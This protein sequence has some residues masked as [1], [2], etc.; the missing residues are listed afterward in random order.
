MKVKIIFSVL[1]TMLSWAS[2][3]RNGRMSA[4]NPVDEPTSGITQGQIPEVTLKALQ[5][6]KSFHVSATQSFSKAPDLK[7]PLE[8]IAGKYFVHAGATVAEQ[9][10]PSDAIIRITCI[11]K[12]SG[13]N[14][15]GQFLYTGGTLSGT[16]SMELPGVAPIIRNFKDESE[17]YPVMRMDFAYKYIQPSAFTFASGIR[18][19]NRQIALLVGELFGA[20]GLAQ[21]ISD[22]DLNIKTAAIDALGK[23]KDPSSVDVLIEALGDTEALSVAVIA[24]GEI[25]DPRAVEPLLI[26]LGVALDPRRATSN[27]SHIKT[28][29]DL[30]NFVA[31]FPKWNAIQALG[32]IGDPRA[33]DPLIVL[34]RDTQFAIRWRSAEALGRIRDRKAVSPLIAALDDPEKLV[35][36]HALKAL[37]HISGKSFGRK[38]KKWQEWWEHE[39]S[40][41]TPPPLS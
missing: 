6:A 20:K 3:G 27:D 30:G 12:P 19:Y 23:L 38:G 39:G 37:E 24:L 9:S 11:G 4:I 10:K 31:Q 21:A 8:E 18:E 17:P 26:I 35:R 1:I 15:K 41:K 36:E 5:S 13:A 7:L 14:Y 25:G 16:I 2:L 29:E 34:L 32:K 28:V 33:V 40:I 22:P